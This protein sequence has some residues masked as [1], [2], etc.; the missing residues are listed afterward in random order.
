MAFSAN[1]EARQTVDPQRHLELVPS[2]GSS[3]GDRYFEIRGEQIAGRFAAY[4]ATPTAND[5]LKQT[6]DFIW[7]VNSVSCPPEQR[8]TFKE[9]IVEALLAYKFAHGYPQD[10]SAGVIF[11]D[12]PNATAY[13]HP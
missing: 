9:V 2:G 4:I 5:A 10:Q 6:C 8:S 1:N 13:R 7:I 3:D 12:D 11:G